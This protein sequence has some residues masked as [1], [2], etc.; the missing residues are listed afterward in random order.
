MPPCEQIKRLKRKL[1]EVRTKFVEK[2]IKLN[3]VKLV[4]TEH[5]NSAIISI[6]EKAKSTII[7]LTTELLEA[8]DRLE[9]MVA[10]V[11]IL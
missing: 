4:V 8:N 6:R 9:E 11:I 2:D 3:H 1:C 10:V 5:L 7:K